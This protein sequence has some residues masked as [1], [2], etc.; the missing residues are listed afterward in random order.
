MIHLLLINL[1]SE[2]QWMAWRAAQRVWGGAVSVQ[3]TDAETALAILHHVAPYENAPD[4]SLTLIA[5]GSHGCWDPVILQHLRDALME[6]G[7]PLVGLADTSRALEQLRARR[8]PLDAVLLS[9][10]QPEAL[11]ELAQMLDSKKS[12]AC[13]RVPI[14]PGPSLLA[15]PGR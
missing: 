12:T 7:A 8:A 13:A 2:A 15:A 4:P 1:T 6:C 9:P 11:S 14:E 10:V 3:S 5:T